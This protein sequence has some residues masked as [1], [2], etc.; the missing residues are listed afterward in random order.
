M[1]SWANAGESARMRRRERRGLRRL[2][3]DII[4]AGF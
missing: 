3:S 2:R 4:V 1:D